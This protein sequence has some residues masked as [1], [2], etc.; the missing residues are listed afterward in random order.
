M[1]FHIVFLPKYL[2]VCLICVTTCLHL[3]CLQKASAS[4][5]LFFA[6]FTFWRLLHGH[7][8]PCHLQAAPSS[9]LVLTC[10]IRTFDTPLN[11]RR[12]VLHWLFKL[13]LRGVSMLMGSRSPGPGVPVSWWSLLRVVAASGCGDC[14]V[15]FNHL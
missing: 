3:T 10:V 7:S 15:Y 2:A 4:D 11:V 9:R 13:T 14:F 5:R 6:I 1:S 8:S 12:W